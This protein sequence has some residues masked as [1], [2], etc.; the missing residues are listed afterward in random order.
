MYATV[1]DR[2][3]FDELNRSFFGIQFLG[4]RRRHR[5]TLVPRRSDI[6]ASSDLWWTVGRLTLVGRSTGCP[7]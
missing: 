1:S 3:A 4:S 6:V 2:I 7:F 5:M